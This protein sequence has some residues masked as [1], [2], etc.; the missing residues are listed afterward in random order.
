LL[1]MSPLDWAE[2]Y[3][4]QSLRELA[5]HGSLVREL[6]EWARS[7]K[8][9][10]P[11][12]ILHGKPGV[13]KTTA[14]LALARDMGW[15][16][17][18]L[19]AS[20]QRTAEV[21]ERVAGP[22]S[23]IASFSGGRRLVILDEADNI[24]GTAD[25]GGERALV[26]VIKNACQPIILIANEL[27]DMSA[28]L[29][30]AGKPVRVGS[31]QTRSVVSVLRRICEEEGVRVEGDVLERIAERAGGD[32]RGAIN[33]L[34]AVAQGET[35]L[36]SISVGERDIRETV[37]R[38]VA[39]VLKTEN[40]KEAV[41]ALFTIDET[42]E[43]FIH[44]IDEN[45][46]LEYRDKNDLTLGYDA[47]SRADVYLGRA[48][49][50]QDYG[51]WRYAA[52]LMTAGVA[53]SKS[54]RYAGYT[55]YQFPSTWRRLGSTKSMRGVRD[56][57]ASKIGRHCHTSQRYAKTDILSYLKEMFKDED[58]AC[59]LIAL[60]DLTLEET[61]LL[62]DGK[63]TTKKV[64]KLHEKGMALREAEELRDIE[65]LGGFQTKTE[66]KPGQEKT[67]GKEEPKKKKEKKSKEKDKEKGE[68]RAKP[69]STLF[70]F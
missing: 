63:T 61:A 33:D 14:A 68:K 34:Q 39:K 21:I 32:L 57:L 41:D 65:V 53:L 5:G 67:T 60:L 11:A 36:V 59:K 37:F 20:D 15:D 62:L 55:K 51:L 50:K 66:E 26:K 54:K 4:P 7:W 49:S 44:W 19:N 69:Q 8:P 46:A 30:T 27:Y 47:L 10:S 3:R 42:P 22:A 17:I 35:E 16:V 70:D 6:L 24:H 23:Q 25:R 18:E 45:L 40:V 48:R 9:G 31:V 28:G 2:K 13:G 56:S 58:T 52:L 38:V 64:Q 29:R 1:S 43:D 12:L